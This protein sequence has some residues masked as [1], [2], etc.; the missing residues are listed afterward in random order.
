MGR[1]CSRTRETPI[2]AK[3]MERVLKGRIISKF[4]QST[5]V[6]RNR[7]RCFPERGYTLVIRMRDALKL[8]SYPCAGTKVLQ[9]A[10]T[11]I[12]SISGTQCLDY[13][14]HIFAQTSV[15]LNISLHSC[16]I[17]RDRHL[18]FIES[19]SMKKIS[20]RLLTMLPGAR[21]DMVD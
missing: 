4:R 20:L 15:D 21:M 12:I 2:A 18:P 14:S 17:A 6:K 1:K 9:S 7:F 19:R 16:S 13:L 10:P 5:G 3:Q 11:S 8:N